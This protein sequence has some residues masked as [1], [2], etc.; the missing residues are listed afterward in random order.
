MREQTPVLPCWN[1][2]VQKGFHYFNFSNP[3]SS[4]SC[5]SA[6]CSEHN[7]EFH[8][9]S[10]TRNPYTLS[11]LRNALCICLIIS[12]GRYTRCIWKMSSQSGRFT[13]V[14]LYK[15][16]W[17]IAAILQLLARQTLCPSV[18][19]A[20]MFKMTFPCTS[21]SSIETTNW[22]RKMSHWWI[23][24]STCHRACSGKASGA[25]TNS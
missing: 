9:S 7:S 4:K 5:L 15:M 6:T 2:P 14:S 23:L 25:K 11:S 13:L 3:G 10:S 18:H 24:E 1:Y 21:T 12:V 16:S 20:N 17:E 19:R 22:D 8:L